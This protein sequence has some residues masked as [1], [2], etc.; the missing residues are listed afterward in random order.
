[1]LRQQI[2]QRKEYLYQKALLENELKK[3]KQV[4]EIDGLLSSGK[5]L[6][7]D[8][9]E[10]VLIDNQAYLYD[11]GIT[12]K[13]TI[14]DEYSTAGLKD[15]KIL[16]TTS[17]NPSSRLLSFSKELKLIF[18]NSIRVNR[19][20]QVLKAVVDVCHSNDVTDLIIVHEHRGVPNGLSI[21]HFPHGPTAFFS[22]FNVVLRHD[23]VEKLDHV[24]EVCPH[25]IFNNFS[26]NLGSRVPILIT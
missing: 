24:S 6:S 13:S 19:G 4:D 5:K 9:K 2:R 14:D 21:S 11:R 17:R 23:M 8:S 7:N 10:A 25:L 22:L 15:P 26:T 12:I 18:P 20:G 16:I 1:M 3:K